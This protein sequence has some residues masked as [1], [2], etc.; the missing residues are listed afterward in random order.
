MATRTQA[1]QTRNQVRG[2]VLIWTF[3]TLAMGMA[4]FLAIYFAYQP[5]IELSAPSVANNSNNTGGSVVVIES[6]TP[7][8]ATETPLP[9]PTSTPMAEP[10]TEEVVAVAQAA[11]EI[12]PTAEPEPTFVPP[13][14]D[15][16]FRVG[17]QIQ[18]P[19]DLNPDVMNG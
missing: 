1:R 10:T 6:Q 14:E 13:D 19:P 18:V 3:I 2:F 11:T 7:L 4:T 8:P 9:L 16:T 15:E 17:I 5:Q 12:P